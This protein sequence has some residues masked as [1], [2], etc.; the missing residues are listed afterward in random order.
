MENEKIVELNT[1]LIDL[2]SFDCEPYIG[3]SVTIESVTEHEGNFGYYIKIETVK[4]A[5]FN[6][7]EIK[8]SKLFGLQT[9]VNGQIGWGKD[10]KL[11]LY[12]VKKQVEHYKNLIGLAVIIQ[13]KTNK[14][15]IDFLDFN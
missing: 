5:E 9:D 3:K 11:G 4:V 12:L 2:P 8:A 10:T 6:G 15:G 14:D 13:T 7:K 1:K